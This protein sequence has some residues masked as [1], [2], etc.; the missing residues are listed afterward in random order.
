[1]SS[2]KL[3]VIVG[4]TGNQGGSVATTF[5]KEPGWKVRALTR[6]ASSAKSQALA[7]R[8]AEV[9]EANIDAPESLSAAFVD[10]NAIFAVSDYWGQY[11]DPSNQNKAK[12]GQGLNAWVGEHETQQLKNQI[13]A[14]A[15]VPTLE[16]FILSSLS[17]ATKWSKG[18]YTHVYHFDS[19]AKAEV[20][21]KQTYPDLWAKT[22]IY[23]AGIFLSNF[24]AGGL[25]TPIKNSDGLV[26]FI[27][28]LEADVKFP[29]VAA[30]EDTGPLVKALVQESAGKN[31]IG[32]RE[33]LTP[34]EIASSFTK[35]TGLKA[36]VVT[37]PKGSFP[38]SMS[39]EMKQSLGDNTG[40]WNEFGYEGREDPTVIHPRDLKSPP[41]LET[42]EDYFKKYDWTKVF[43]S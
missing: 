20:Y 11:F 28:L 9:V 1:M 41:S 23:Q 2:S 13:D 32:Y 24:F 22:S 37:L 29:Y 16:R 18:K 6:D 4:A 21:G 19:K 34:R 5:L 43:S 25:S 10:A 14:A 27:G 40:Y 7:A 35:A 17:D 31:L 38:P 15:K 3:I 39:A 30:E 42:S 12:P 26:Q 8:G 33:W 36:E